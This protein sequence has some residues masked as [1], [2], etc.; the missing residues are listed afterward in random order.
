[1]RKVVLFALW[2]LSVLTLTAQN[3]REELKRDFYL[4]KLDTYMFTSGFQ[5]MISPA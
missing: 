5:R 3:V 2:A 1:M 4:K